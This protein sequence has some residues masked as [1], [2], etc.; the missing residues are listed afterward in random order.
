MSKLVFN[1]SNKFG[2]KPDIRM[3]DGRDGVSNEYFSTSDVD[4]NLEP[5]A[6]KLALTSTG[7]SGAAGKYAYLYGPPLSGLTQTFVFAV[8]TKTLTGNR[9]FFQV[10]SSSSDYKNCS[11]WLDNSGYLS[12]NVNCISMRMGQKQFETKSNSISAEEVVNLVIVCRADGAVEVWKGGVEISDYISA[13]RTAFSSSPHHRLCGLNFS[14]SIDGGVQLFVRQD[15]DITSLQACELSKDVF[16]L[17]KADKSAANNAVYTT[18]FAAAP[19]A[20]IH[21]HTASGGV[22]TSGAANVIQ[23]KGHIATGG[24]VTGGS[25]GIAT[26]KAHQATGGVITGGSAVTEQVSAGLNSYNHT[27]SGGVTTSGAA[28]VIQIKE[29]IATGGVIT[30]GSAGI[31]TTKAH[32]ATGGIITG[33]TAAIEQV[34][35][36]LNSYS[37]TASG[38]VTTSGTANVIQIKGH[39]AAGGVITG[40]SAI[41]EQISA[42]LNSYSHTASGGITTS[43]V[44]NV[45]QIKEHIA[46][47]GV[48]TGGSAI[49]NKKTWSAIDVSDIQMQLTDNEYSMKLSDKYI[50]EME[51]IA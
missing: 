46:T 6:N 36:G 1:K 14:T 2:I 25:A 38:G 42:G 26:T 11:I 16:Q 35:A 7:G 34:S 31:A 17:F 51:L 41:T 43:G 47:G 27:A 32:Q 21:S 5:L 12:G 48:T 20:V 15:K 22:T 37:H 28:S 24:I 19:V 13:G 23:I 3:I 49:M 18:L 29:H 30:G 4:I 10:S 45:V 39:I 44:A 33:G 9:F 50:I 40:G 8:Y